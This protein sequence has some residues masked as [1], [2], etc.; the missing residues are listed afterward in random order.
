MFK[1]LETTQ[2]TGKVFSKVPPDFAVAILNPAGNAFPSGTFLE[3]AVKSV[4]GNKI[5]DADL[6]W[7]RRSTSEFK[8]DSGEIPGMTVQF[9]NHIDGCVY[10]V[11]TSTAGIEAVVGQIF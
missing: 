8:D 2:T 9:F 7:K 4:D 3:Y 10:R 5:A 6:V 1:V 11:V